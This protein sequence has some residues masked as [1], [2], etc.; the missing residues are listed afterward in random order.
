LDLY[1]SWTTLESR[2][3]SLPERG[4]I[5]SYEATGA[6][7][8]NSD[9]T[10][11]EILRRNRDAS[12]IPGIWTNSPSESTSGGSIFGVPWIRMVK[13]SMLLQPRRDQRA[14]ERFLRRLLRGQEPAINKDAGNCWATWEQRP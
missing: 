7:A 5:V 13:S 10:M 14:A 9:P 1:P 2:V 3:R 6:G 4:I 11:P 8:G 12:V